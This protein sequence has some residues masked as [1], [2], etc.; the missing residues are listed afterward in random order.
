MKKLSMIV[1]LLGITAALVAGCGS[2]PEPTATPAPTYTPY[3]EPT[4]YPTYT[5]NPT[6]TPYPEPTPYPTYTPYPEPEPQLPDLTNLFCEYE[7]CIGHPTEAHLTDIQAPEEWNTYRNG[8]VMGVS[9]T[10]ILAVEWHIRTRT[11]WNLENEI[12]EMIDKDTPLADVTEEMMGQYSVAYRPFQTTDKY[13]VAGAWYCG[14]R[15]FK[16]M[17]LVDDEDEGLDML[18]QAME[19]FTCAED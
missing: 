4:P 18:R 14:E 1:L 7:F 6:A 10:G 9:A 15:G 17:V 19:A 8:V 2:K 3:P 16:A 13:G 11:E 5:P 12:D